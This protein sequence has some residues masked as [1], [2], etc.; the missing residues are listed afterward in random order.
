MDSVGSDLFLRGF[1]SLLPFG[2][3]LFLI[4]FGTIGRMSKPVFS[5]T[6][7]S[8]YVILRTF[9][10]PLLEVLVILILMRSPRTS[11]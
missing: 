11:P 7:A 4:S 8:V 5:K 10:S 1:V 9:H 3:P 6:S 2:L